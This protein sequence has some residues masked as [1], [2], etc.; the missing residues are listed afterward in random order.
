MYLSDN[1][2]RSD[3]MDTHLLRSRSDSFIPSEE[4]NLVEKAGGVRRRCGF[5][6][7]QRPFLNKAA[8]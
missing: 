2:W 8:V 6:E 3:G 7:K 4:A 5:E 1:V